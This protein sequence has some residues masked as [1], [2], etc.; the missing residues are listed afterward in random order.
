M[1]TKWVMMSAMLATM[2]VSSANAAG[3]N[4]WRTRTT[5]PTAQPAPA[6]P[7][8]QPEMGQG[9]RYAPLDNSIPPG[10]A[11]SQQMTMPTQPT[12]PPVPY[13]NQNFGPQGGYGQIP[14]YGPG[15]GNRPYPGGLGGY[16][17]RGLGGPFG[18]SYGGP[19]GGYGPR[20]GGWNGMNNGLNNG[21][22]S[23]MPFW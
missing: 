6:E 10:R 15:N 2:V 11:Q 20:N 14:G 18:N 19:M 13:G 1:R 17:G 22:W 21:P 23:W 7:A 4:P 9:Y 12:W 8:P 3:T 16:P 5:S